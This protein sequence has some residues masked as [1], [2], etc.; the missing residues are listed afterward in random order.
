MT[1]N[2]QLTVILLRLFYSI[3]RDFYNVKTCRPVYGVETFLGCRDFF[4]DVAT[5]RAVLWRG[6]VR[7]KE[8]LTGFQLV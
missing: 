3:D 1:L 6:D 7:C 8:L 4:C 2:K 5:F